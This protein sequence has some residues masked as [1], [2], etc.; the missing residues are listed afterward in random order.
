[1]KAGAVREDRSPLKDAI[2]CPNE[3]VI[4]H[5]EG[6]TAIPLGKTSTIH[7][8]MPEQH[9]LPLHLASCLKFDQKTPL[10]IV[11]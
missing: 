6:Q 4:F 11:E 7:G 10:A 8:L 3:Y 1:M 2:D 9:H 5:V